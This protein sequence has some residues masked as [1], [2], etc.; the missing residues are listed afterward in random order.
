MSTFC[1]LA[2]KESTNSSRHT[3]YVEL[4]L[5][6][7]RGLILYFSGVGRKYLLG[8][9]RHGSIKYRLLLILGD[10]TWK[11]SYSNNTRDHDLQLFL[12]HPRY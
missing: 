1:F 2:C 8:E 12:F 5:Q 7:L 4:G 6:Q 11:E 3:R 10:T 9:N